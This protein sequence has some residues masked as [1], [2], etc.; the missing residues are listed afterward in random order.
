MLLTTNWNNNTGSG[1]ISI[2][3]TANP[4]VPIFYNARYVELKGN[5]FISKNLHVLNNS[6]FSNR[7]TVSCSSGGGN[8]RSTPSA[9]GLEYSIGFYT[10]T[11]LRSAAAGDLF[12]ARMHS[13][14][15]TGFSIGP[16]MKHS[17]LNIANAGD[18]TIP[19]SLNTSN[20]TTNA[21]LGVA[22]KC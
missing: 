19:Y 15:K 17:C 21:V 14:S 1:S 13:R 16:P 2:Q 6:S 4:D 3:N 18:I 5:A 7:I 20:I 8:I 11:D 10:Y 22:V 9:G 12:V